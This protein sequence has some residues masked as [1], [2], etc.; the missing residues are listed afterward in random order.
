MHSR[1]ARKKNI[2]K[3]NKSVP[4][5]WMIFLAPLAFFEIHSTPKPA[6][7]ASDVGG[8]EIRFTK[9]YLISVNALPSSDARQALLLRA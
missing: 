3:G 9:P 6:N 2:R 5:H 4:F 7:I 8:I 1:K